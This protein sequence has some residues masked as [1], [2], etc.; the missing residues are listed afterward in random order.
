[1]Q[2]P[3]SLWGDWAVTCSCSCRTHKKTL[4]LALFSVPLAIAD[5]W[6]VCFE[7]TL[8]SSQVRSCLV[9]DVQGFSCSTIRGKGA[10]GGGGGGRALCGSRGVA[11][12]GYCTYIGYLSIQH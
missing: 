4:F 7:R 1:M 3:V 11:A 9:D 12:F 5:S 10:W 2:T 6:V 8:G